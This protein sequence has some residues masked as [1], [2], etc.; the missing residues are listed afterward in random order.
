M[1][2]TFAGVEAFIA[3]FHER[4]NVIRTELVALRFGQRVGLRDTAEPHGAHQRH[5]CDG[6][7]GFQEAP[8]MEA[9]GEG[10]GV[11]IRAHGKPLL[12]DRPR[13]ERASP[14]AGTVSPASVIAAAN[15][16]S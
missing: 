5:R 4:Q 12:R 8:P 7:G 10:A 1:V 15:V 2:F 11:L 16:R 9:V 13:I 6:A 14:V 3:L